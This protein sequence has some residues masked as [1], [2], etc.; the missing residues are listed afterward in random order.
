MDGE[1]EEEAHG[2]RRSPNSRTG[3]A[4]LDRHGLQRSRPRQGLSSRRPPISSHIHMFSPHRD[5]T[6]TVLSSMG[7]PPG[8]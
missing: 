3:A 2:A 1:E 7:T 5:L 6:Y 8:C 4:R